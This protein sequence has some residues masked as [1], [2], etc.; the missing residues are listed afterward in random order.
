MIGNT[1]PLPQIVQFVNKMMLALGNGITPYESDGTTGGTTQI[2]NTFSATYPTWSATTVYNQ[3]DQIQVTSGASYVFTAQQGGESGSS[4]PAFSP[5]LGSTVADGNIIWKNSGQVTGS[6]PPRGAAHAEVYAG[7]LWVA[8]TSPTETSD[9][10]DGPSAL[11]MS[12]LNNPL[13]WNPLNAAQIEP[14]D[15]DQCTGIKAFTIAEAGIAPQ[16][17]L[18]YFKNFSSYV[19]Q[20]VFGSSDFSITRLQTDL[21]CVAPRTLQFVPGYGIMRLTHLGFAVTDGI[22][23]KLQDPEAIR[24]YLFPESTESDIT[25][26]DQSYLYFCK[27]AQTS[28]PPMY[29]CACPLQGAP[30]AAFSGVSLAVVVSQLPPSTLTPGNYYLKI[31]ATL[32]NGQVVVSGEYVLL[33]PSGGGGNPPQRAVYPQNITIQLPINVGVTSWAIYVGT[34]SNG[35]NKFITVPGGQSSAVINNATSFTAGTPQTAL[36]GELTRLFCYD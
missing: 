9:Q 27:A 26:I 15:G 7:S 6:P 19:I 18:T 31:A 13:S 25:P 21:G 23:D 8:N 30:A 20:G 33:A 5:T 32:T 29:V 17:F 12:D 36:G 10:L 24:P 11:R 1:S 14:D 3:G 4:T 22:S 28:N 35:E 16:N 2:T 34:T